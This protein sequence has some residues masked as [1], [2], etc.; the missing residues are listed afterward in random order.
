MRF[1]LGLLMLFQQKFLVAPL[2][3]QWEM[4]GFKGQV[5]DGDIGHSH[6]RGCQK[7][8]RAN[9]WRLKVKSMKI[10][11]G[12]FVGSICMAVLG[13]SFR[14]TLFVL[15]NLIKT[16]LQNDMAILHWLSTIQCG[17]S[18]CFSTQ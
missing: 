3:S 15:K 1:K 14:K 12:D 5:G 6:E 7:W 2:L 10:M 9:K 16:L 18:T 17:D 8:F 13:F 11:I 4:P